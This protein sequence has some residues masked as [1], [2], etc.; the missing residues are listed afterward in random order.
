MS[1]NGPNTARPKNYPE[2]LREI[3]A[4]ALPK[5]GAE[6][7]SL[8]HLVANGSLEVLQ[9]IGELKFVFESFKSR[10]EESMLSNDDA[11]KRTHQLLSQILGQYDTSREDFEAFQLSTNNAIAEIRRRIGHTNGSSNGAHY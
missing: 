4:E 11:H 10:I 8:R 6:L 5:I 2:D 1:D 7:D 3:V 9:E